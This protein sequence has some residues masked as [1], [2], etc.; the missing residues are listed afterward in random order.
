MTGLSQFL[1]STLG[2]KVVMAVSGL[3]LF[4]FVIA[5]MLGNL[6][7]YL[8]PKALNDYAAALRKVPELLWAARA[9]LLVA[10]LAHIWAAYGLTRMNWAARPEGY[11]EKQHRESTLASRT[12]RWSGVLVLFFIVYHLL[13]LTFGTVHPDFREGD[14]FHNFVVGFQNPLVSAF[15]I[16]A[17]LFLALHLFHG[18]WSWLQTLGLSHP[19]YNGLRRT[20]AVLIT[21]VVVLGNLSFPIAVMAGLI[22]ERPATAA[23]GSAR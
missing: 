18:A 11:R 14:A 4:G 12:M 1:G 9:G 7:V 15:Y 10:A 19:R 20:L 6:Q 8:G 23:H 22:G 21:A 3:A 17:T 2:K 16:V 13:H 5:H